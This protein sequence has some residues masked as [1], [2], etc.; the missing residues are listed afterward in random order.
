[1]EGGNE[2][3]CRGYHFTIAFKELEGEDTVRRSR[4]DIP[5]LLLE[6]FEKLHV[7]NPQH[8]KQLGGGLRAA[9]ML[10]CQPLVVANA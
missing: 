4:L 1:M 6:Y 7:M 9:Y 2:K 5:L 10:L 3:R 8:V